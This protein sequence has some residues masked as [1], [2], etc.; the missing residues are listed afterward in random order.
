MRYGMLGDDP[1]STGEKLE[2]YTGEVDW[3]YLRPHFESGALL[4]I[5]PS[6]SLIEVGYA[7]TEDDSER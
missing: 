6:I 1:G 2:K 5:D 4:Y 3:N 7:L